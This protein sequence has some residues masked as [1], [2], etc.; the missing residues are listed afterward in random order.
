MKDDS[1]T[2]TT[3]SVSVGIPIPIS[4]PT[5]PLLNQ[6]TSSNVRYAIGSVPSSTGAL[7]PA[8]QPSPFLKASKSPLFASAS[9][10]LGAA[11]PLSGPTSTLANL[12]AAPPPLISKIKSK[13]YMLHPRALL[14]AF[15]SLFYIRTWITK[16]QRSMYISYQY[17]SISSAI[18]SMC[19][20]W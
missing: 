15:I 19:D 10:I 12:P 8:E 6:V 16:Y 3:T 17:H 2:A 11:H 7:L 20:V 5:S 9:P 4:T 14:A 1:S 13:L 18:L